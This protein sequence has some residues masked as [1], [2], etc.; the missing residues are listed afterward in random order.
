MRIVCKNNIH[1]INAKRGGSTYRNASLNM[2]KEGQVLSASF[3][4]SP[5]GT[6]PPPPTTPPHTHFMRPSSHPS[7]V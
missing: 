6:Q 7:S 3:P 1:L 5:E 4:R 2:I